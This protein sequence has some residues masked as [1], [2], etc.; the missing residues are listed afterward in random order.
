MFI[1]YQNLK[2]IFT[3]VENVNMNY[4]TYSEQLEN[5]CKRNQIL[6]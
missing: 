6:I 1:S 4:E 5:V 3:D 2:I